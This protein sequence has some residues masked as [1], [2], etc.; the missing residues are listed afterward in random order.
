MTPPSEVQCPDMVPTEYSGNDHTDIKHKKFQKK[1]S[2]HSLYYDNLPNLTFIY[3]LITG[4]QLRNISLR[5]GESLIITSIFVT[6]LSSLSLTVSSGSGST[7][8]ITL[9]VYLKR[10]GRPRFADFNQVKPVPQL[11]ELSCLIRLILEN[12]SFSFTMVVEI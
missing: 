11:V 9:A 7:S 4:S 6:Q 12:G 5:G 8:A 3:F 2:F 10:G 1:V